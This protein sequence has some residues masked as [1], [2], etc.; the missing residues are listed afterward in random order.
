MNGKEKCNLL[1]AMRKEIAEANGI[2]YLS[3]ECDQ[4]DGCPGYCPK[5]DEEARYLDTELER[6]EAEGIEIKKYN[7]YADLQIT[8]L[9]NQLKEIEESV[10][11]KLD[12]AS[13]ELNGVRALAELKNQIEEEITATAENLT[14][15]FEYGNVEFATMGVILPDDLFP[16]DDPQ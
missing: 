2:V 15:L 1:K 12:Q 14:S 9:K 6:L 4:K 7:T 10:T 13:K 11:N 5:C 3:A 16:D 8:S